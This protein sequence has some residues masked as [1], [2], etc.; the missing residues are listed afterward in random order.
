[1]YVLLEELW[2]DFTSKIKSSRPHFGL[3]AEKIFQG[4]TTTTTKN[5]RGT[6]QPSPWPRVRIDVQCKGT[7]TPLTLCDQRPGVGFC[8]FRVGSL[9]L[10]SVDIRN[11]TTKRSFRS[12]PLVKESE[13][14][15]KGVRYPFFWLRR[16]PSYLT[17]SSVS[18][19]FT[20][21]TLSLDLLTKRSGYA[22]RWHDYERKN[23]RYYDL[24]TQNFFFYVVVVKTGHN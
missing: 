11:F 12:S 8:S 17:D 21:R 20:I 19:A 3:S 13:W 14:W 4:S 22:N 9:P 18:W 10:G 1:M 24:V 7:S 15:W 5:W 16:I 23:I 2:T 6:H